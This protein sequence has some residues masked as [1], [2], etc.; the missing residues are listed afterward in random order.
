MTS[1]Y[2][3]EAVDAAATT[4]TVGVLWEA[5]HSSRPPPW[6]RAAVQSNPVTDK[7][8]AE[9]PPP[10]RSTLASTHSDI[11][12]VAGELPGPEPG[13]V[14]AAGMGSR[15]SCKTFTTAE[16]LMSMAQQS[17]PL[18]GPGPDPGP[19]KEGGWWW[20]QRTMAAAAITGPTGSSA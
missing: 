6:A 7:C 20:L 5:A 9:G 4:E 8:S 13:P 17:P 14:S 16:S 3:A 11:R 10:D 19:E 1:A 2:L 15:V 18:P 12:L